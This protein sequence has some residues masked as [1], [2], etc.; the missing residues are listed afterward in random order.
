MDKFVNYRNVSSYLD[1]CT[2]KKET[3]N[4]NT[5]HS[6]LSVPGQLP[7]LKLFPKK[8]GSS[9]YHVTI[10]Y[11]LLCS[12][13]PLHISQ[14]FFLTKGKLGMLISNQENFH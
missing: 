1:V 11:I 9:C 12:N 6:N 3:D 14:S 5:N 8:Q 13:K 4:K 7:E 10:A 2:G